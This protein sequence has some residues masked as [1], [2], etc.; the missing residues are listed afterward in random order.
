MSAP[1]PLTIALW[2]ANGWIGN[3]FKDILT[4]LGHTV[5]IPPMRA[6]ADTSAAA[7][8]DEMRPDR[9]VSMIGRTHGE[10]CNTID[11]LERP[12]KLVENVRDNL[13]SPVALALICAQRGIHY[14]YLGTGCIFSDDD[15]T[16]HS[17]DEA[18]VPNF[19]GSSY[20]I[21]K[22]FTDRLF[23]LLDSTA[24]QA[25]I[26][27]PIVGVKHP[28]NFITKITQYAKVCSIPNSMSVLP[29]LLPVLAHMVEDKRTGTV[30]LVNPGLISHNEILE[31]YK[32]LV[33]PNFKWENFT[34]E[35]QNL[36]LAS[37]RSSNQMDTT[38]LERLY[39]RVP[40][41]RDAVRTCLEDMAGKNV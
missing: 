31:M 27:M 9:V 17:Y 36:I 26:R 22:G 29:T 25:R 38:Y 19:F 23:H 10:G 33:D 40:S 20:S 8:L 13:Y 4:Y 21:V 37:K 15:P 18:A 34:I 11:Y 41:I 1:T 32:E 6:D 16:T 28:R 14:T 24:L 5:L 30:N 39:P 7:W 12:G 35:E 3:Q 2:G